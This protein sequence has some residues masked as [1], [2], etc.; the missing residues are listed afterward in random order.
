MTKHEDLPF[1]V[2]ISEAINDIK[3]SLKGHTKV[4][5]AKNK[6][7]RDANVRRIEII[8]EAVKNISAEIKKKYPRVEW[9]KIAGARDIMIHHYFGI[10]LNVVWEILTS[11][12]P[13]M[14]REIK[15][16]LLMVKKRRK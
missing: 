8:G 12:V 11:D 5:F 16:I 7:V 1:L 6:D 14:E 4:S 15:D 13:K 9:K 10:D 3:D 2:H